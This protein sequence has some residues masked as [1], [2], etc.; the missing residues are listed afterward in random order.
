VV[1]TFHSYAA[2]FTSC[3]N[4]P[5]LRRLASDIRALQ[6]DVLLTYMVHPWTPFLQRYLRDIP[7]VV[8]V[9]DPA[10][11]PGIVHGL[12]SWWE[13]LSA[14]HA[15]R[16]VVMSTMFV[17]ELKSKRVPAERIDVIP[18]AVLSLYK[19]DSGDGKTQRNPNLVLFFGRIT[20]YKGLDILLR[21]FLQVI[22]HVPAAELE[23]V[24]EGD[25][26]PYLRL[27][28]ESDRVR[29]VNRWVA[30]EDVGDFFRRAAIVVLP[31]TSATQS[32]VAAIAAAFGV[33][34]VASRV[35]A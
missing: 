28:A 33:P 5:R 21:A 3:V 19:S 11:H 30:D 12:S 23:V 29:V 32:G 2:A 34:V 10:A 27:L 6:P 4:L 14:R 15:T 35:G 26:S 25:I 16:A 8:T 9:H 24:G 13:A 1:D 22:S 7:H 31:Y 20:T 17:G 18:H